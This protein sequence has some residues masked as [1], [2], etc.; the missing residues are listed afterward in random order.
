M[1]IDTKVGGL[2]RGVDPLSCRAIP[3]V[4]EFRASC[5]AKRFP[6]AL[7]IS[8]AATSVGVG[9]PHSS[10][11]RSRSVDR[12]KRL[13]LIEANDSPP[14]LSASHRAVR[15]VKAAGFALTPWTPARDGY[16]ADSSAQ[17]AA[18]AQSVVVPRLETY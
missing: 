5:M 4:S 8:T 11:V 14:V 7:T 17:S 3:R 16:P 13:T 12:C 15:Y 18:I 9:P 2:V 6:A 10:G 1:L